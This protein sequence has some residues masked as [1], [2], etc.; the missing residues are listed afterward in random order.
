MYKNFLPRLCRSQPLQSRK[1]NKREQRNLRTSRKRIVSKGEYS[2]L[3]G[4][5]AAYG[6]S[7]LFL[8]EFSALCVVLC[9][10]FLAGGFA[11]RGDSALVIKYLCASL[12]FGVLAF[13]SKCL[14]EKQMQQARQKLNARA[15]H[16][17]PTPATCLRQR[18][19]Y[20][21]HPNLFKRRKPFC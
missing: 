9:A 12:L 8:A 2:A 3:V 4:Q 6:L 17:L 20:A 5:K 19:L 7:S 21:H 18:A 16:P 13:G 1:R 15:S 11:S 14:A 10:G